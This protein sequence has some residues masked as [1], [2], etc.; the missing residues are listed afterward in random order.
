[1]EPRITYRSPPRPW[2]EAFSFPSLTAEVTCPTARARAVETDH[3]T[4]TAPTWTRPGISIPPDHGRSRRRHRP[5]RRGTSASGRVK[6]DFP[7]PGDGYVPRERRGGRLARI[8]HKLRPTRHRDGET[9][10]PARWSARPVLHTGCGMGLEATLYPGRTRFVRVAGTDACPGRRPSAHTA[11]RWPNKRDPRSLG[12][13]PRPA[14]EIPYWQMENLSK[15]EALP[16]F[17][18]SRASRKDQGASPWMDREVEI[19]EA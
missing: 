12:R 10:A 4:T 14:R 19:P 5:R 18:S 7:G 2:P 16:P 13:Q 9:P 3:P 17:G 1:M 15:P 6:L 11:R 8:G